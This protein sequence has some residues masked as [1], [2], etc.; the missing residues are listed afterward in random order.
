MQPADS[1]VVASGWFPFL[2]DD[3]LPVVVVM[4]IL[5]YFTCKL[6]TMSGKVAPS[7]PQRPI[8]RNHANKLGRQSV[9]GRK[10]ITCGHTF[11]RQELEDFSDDEDAHWMRPICGQVRENKEPIDVSDHKDRDGLLTESC[12]AAKMRNLPVRA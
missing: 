5:G 2:P 4:F 6:F 1:C 9:P 12:I 3:E 8:V 10:D 11:G 7:G